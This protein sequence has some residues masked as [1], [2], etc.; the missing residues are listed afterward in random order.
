MVFWE[1]CHA[2]TDRPYHT[3][4]D[5]RGRRSDRIDA[6]AAARARPMQKLLTEAPMRKLFLVTLAVLSLVGGAATLAT[7]TFQPAYACGGSGCN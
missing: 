1:P 3:R 4:S 7:I 5:A 6:I 2:Q